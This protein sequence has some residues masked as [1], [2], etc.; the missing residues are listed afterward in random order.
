MPIEPLAILI[1]INTNIKGLDIAS[2][3]HKICLFSDDVILFITQP[4]TTLP[5]LRKELDNFKMIFGLYINKDKYKALNIN[6]L[7]YDIIHIKANFPFP[8]E[9]ISL[10]YLGIKRTSSYD[11]LYIVNY[12]SS[13]RYLRS[14]LETWKKY[15]ISWLGR[16]TSV[17][18]FFL[19]K[20]LPVKI[21]S[22]ILRSIQ[23]M[24]FSI[25]WHKH[26]PPG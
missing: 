26:K 5:N 7:A 9:N 8:L 18:N 22:H 25:I 20:L 14:L 3:H 11:S 6:M 24:M 16:I 19:P 2:Y 13:I 12:P 1:Q 10:P 15:Q 21:P 4:L 17:K 23:N